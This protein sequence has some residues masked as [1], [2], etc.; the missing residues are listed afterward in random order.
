M[1]LWS[2]AHVKTLIPTT[3]IMLLIAV[4]LRLTIGKKD[5]RIRMIPFQILSG[6]LFLIEIGKQVYSYTHGYDLYHLPF[7]FCS[8]F[9]FMLPLMAFYRGKHEGA[10]RA[11]TVAI[12]TSMFLLL[13]IYPCLIYSADNIKNFFTGYLDFHTV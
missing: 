12:T 11:I 5:M 9:I 13:M 6:L 7:H 8:L 10:V 3:L 4:I 1:E 2:S